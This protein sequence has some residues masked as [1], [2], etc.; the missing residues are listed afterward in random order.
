MEDFVL[1][2]YMS[3]FVIDFIF[4]FFLFDVE[5]VIMSS[6]EKK[7]CIVIILWSEK[8]NKIKEWIKAASVMLL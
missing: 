7:S 1:F 2:A 5:I 6:A 8:K 3:A 4:G